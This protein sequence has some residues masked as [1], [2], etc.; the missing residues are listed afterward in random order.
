MA[1]MVHLEQYPLITNVYSQ[2]SHDHLLSS[3]MTKQINIP[4]KKTIFLN[5]A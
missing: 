1:H 2:N 4:A 3:V 5:D